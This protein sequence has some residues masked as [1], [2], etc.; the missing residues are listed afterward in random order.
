MMHW[1]PSPI[2]N[3]FTKSTKRR[4][5]REGV[6]PMETLKV[7]KINVDFVKI[8]IKIVHFIPVK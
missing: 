8:R 1:G 7:R 6:E 3:I 2:F 5:R 4:L